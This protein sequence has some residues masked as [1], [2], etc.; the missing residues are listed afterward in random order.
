MLKKYNPKIIAVTGSVGKTSTKDAIFTVMSAGHYIRKSEKSFNSEIGVPLTI[1]GCNNAWS[2]PFA[3]LSVFARGLSLIFTKNNY[4]DWLVLEVGADRPGDIESLSAWLRPDVSVVTRFGKTPVHVEFFKNREELVREKSFLVKALK[5]E[6]VAVL[7]YDDEDIRAFGELT[8]SN[9]TFFGFDDG[10]TVKASH[11]KVLTEKT[12]K[13]KMPVGI[14]F[15][16]DVAGV[17]ETI[18]LFGL[19]G[20]HHTYPAL[21]AIAVGHTQGVAVVDMK[22]S[23]QSHIPPRGRMRLIDGLKGSLI[24]DDTYN[25]SPVASLEALHTLASLKEAKR[26]I[27]VLGDMMELGLGSAEAHREIGALAYTACEILVTVGVRS[28]K[29]AES[30]QDAGMSEKNIFQ[31]DD[32]LEAGS[33]IQNLIAEGDVILVKGSQ[34]MRMERTVKEIMLKPEQAGELLVRQEGEWLSR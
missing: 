24:I 14:S 33:F 15:A 10:A 29:I 31:F 25:S 9:K 2:N 30:A 18:E 26:K 13:G 28:R 23:L 16:V 21:A 5:R 20:K 27:A 1:L 4:P 22:L 17:S 32:S 19:L 12:G 6:G 8:E 11:Y 3:W 34:S 7:N